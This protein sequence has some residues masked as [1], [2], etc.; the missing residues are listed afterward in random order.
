MLQNPHQFREPWERLLLEMTTNATADCRSAR[1]KAAS[2]SS[3]AGRE[4][5]S[6]AEAGLTI[7]NHPVK[8]EVGH[9]IPGSRSSLVLGLSFGDM[10]N[11]LGGDLRGG[12]S[13]HGIGEF[14][15]FALSNDL[16]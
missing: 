11:D 6:C 4:P 7:S 1:E 5:A 9:N 10:P 3:N 8:G 13:S 12:F 14:Q 15:Q 2:L 16:A